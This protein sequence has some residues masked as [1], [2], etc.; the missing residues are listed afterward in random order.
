[1]TPTSVPI[2]IGSTSSDV[3]TTS[4]IS[5]VYS[6]SSVTVSVNKSWACDNGSDSDDPTDMLTVIGTPTTRTIEKKMVVIQY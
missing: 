2:P 5:I 4:V 1:M 3:S 6:G